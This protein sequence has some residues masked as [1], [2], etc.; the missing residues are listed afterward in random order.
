[1]LRIGR[2]DYANCTPIFHAL[3]ELAP[4]ADY[5]FVNGVPSQL[6]SLLASGDLD[7]CPSSS[8]EYALHSDQY[9]ILPHI[10]I[11]SC[12][13]VGSVLLLSRLPL[14][15]LDG[16]SVLLSSESATSVNLLKVLLA[17]RFGCTCSY[18]QTSLPFDEA[19]QQAS[20]VLLIGDAALRAS[21]QKPDVHIYDLGDLWHNWTGLPF[22]FA[23]WLCTLS[24]AHTHPEEIGDLSQLL[25]N[26]KELSRS[27]LESVA[28]QALEASWMGRHRLVQYWREN[29]SYELGPRHLEG[30]N[31]F[32]RYCVELGLLPFEPTLH[33][34]HN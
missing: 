27:N 8:F 22:V 3:R 5:R 31:M 20:A 18:A 29:I 1:M 33:F 21:L 2:I 13:A 6:N 14:E 30:L 10:S 23:L 15:E 28:D 25:L 19:L 9:L 24:T 34:L 11:S 4:H 17:R 26:A 7:A 12:G 16:H 32:F